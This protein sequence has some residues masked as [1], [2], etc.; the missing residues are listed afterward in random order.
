[1]MQAPIA[2]LPAYLAPRSL[3]WSHFL[4]DFLM[5]SRPA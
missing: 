2:R 1:M 4:L 5:H 3:P